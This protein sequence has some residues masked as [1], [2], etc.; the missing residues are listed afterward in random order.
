MVRGADY[1]GAFVCAQ[2][3]DLARLARMGQSLFAEFPKTW[4]GKLKKLRALNGR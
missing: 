2:G 3:I 4:P 1:R